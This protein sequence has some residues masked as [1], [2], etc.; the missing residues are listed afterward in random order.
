M[1]FFRVTFHCFLSPSKELPE[2]VFPVQ[3]FM[4]RA[5]NQNE[6]KSAAEYLLAEKCGQADEFHLTGN[7]ELKMYEISLRDIQGESGTTQYP[8]D[9]AFLPAKEKFFAASLEEAKE[10]AKTR[11]TLFGESEGGRVLQYGP[12]E[13][14]E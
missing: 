5:E 12:T 3:Y 8:E 7:E 1:K 6:A 4:L 13:V 11:E 2:G 14:G 9:W 10:I